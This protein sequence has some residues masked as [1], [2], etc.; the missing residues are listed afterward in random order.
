MGVG[1]QVSCLMLPTEV[2]G[3][4]ETYNTGLSVAEP[5]CSSTSRSKVTSAPSRKAAISSATAS[6]SAQEPS[7]DAGNR[8][9]ESSGLGC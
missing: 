8:S 6:I 2:A 7:S 9:R 5:L 3:R 4:G 1:V